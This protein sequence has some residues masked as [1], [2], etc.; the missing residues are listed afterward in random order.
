VQ[1]GRPEGE[2]DQTSARHGAASKFPFQDG[3][4]HVERLG[5]GGQRLCLHRQEQV[6]GA[7]DATDGVE[8][9]G[10]CD[11]FGGDGYL[12][13]HREDSSRFRIGSGGNEDLPACSVRLNAPGEVYRAADH[14]VLGALLGANIAHHDL[15]G[16]N[17]NAHV[18]LRQAGAAIGRI[19]VVQA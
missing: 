15:P 8:G 13:R 9:D 4:A 2:L 1:F 7:L 11:P 3:I 18:D 16:V 5:Q 6:M 14:A 12:V 17:A 19:G 10:C